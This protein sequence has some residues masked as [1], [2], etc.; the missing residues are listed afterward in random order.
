MSDNIWPLVIILVTMVVFTH[1]KIIYLKHFQILYWVQ[2]LPSFGVMECTECFLQASFWCSVRLFHHV[3]CVN[4]HLYK[5]FD[6]SF[7][8][9]ENNLAPG[10]TLFKHSVQNIHRNAVVVTLKQTSQKGY[11]KSIWTLLYVLCVVSCKVTPNWCFRRH[12]Y[13]QD[14]YL[15]EVRTT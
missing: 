3:H 13:H 15:V 10:E 5:S 14:V 8:L 9:E 12:K 2:W 4:S 11:I 6:K 1:H 7:F